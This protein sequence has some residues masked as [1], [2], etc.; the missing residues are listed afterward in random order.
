[1]ATIIASV[2]IFVGIVT[3]HE[4][5]HFAAAK[6]CGVT[7]LE[8]SIGMGPCI[9]QKKHKGTLYSLR[10]IPIGGYCALEG[11]DKESEDEHAFINQS[12]LKRLFI[13]A[14]GAFMN[15]LLG[16]VL[17]CCLM[18]FQN[19]KQVA[20][21]VIS[22]VMENSP[23]Q[24]A[25]LQKND[26]IVKI[27]NSNIKTQADLKFE[28]S[29]YK[30]GDIKLTYL[31]NGEKRTV[32]IT[33]KLIDGE[34][35]IG[36]TAKI[37]PL[38]FGGRIYHAYQYSL[39]FGK[40]ILVS[41]WDVVTGAIGFENM[42]GPVGMVKEINTATNAGIEALL[43]L[44]AIITIN[45]GL[46]NLLPLPALDGG[47]ILF[48]FVE[49]IIRKKIPPEKEGLIHLLGFLLLIA[50]MLFATWNDILRLINK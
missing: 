25:G 10:C 37:E 16:F 1:M 23:A 45:L 32:S 33:P 38:D 30:G 4:F 47:R 20:V 24:E 36:Y 8:F 2:I 19:A 35:L 40:V 14:A 5:G 31:R 21:P 17:M 22:S 44:A 46:F 27:N 49:L 18:F 41:L 29:R 9:F 12:P 50:L 42:S 13:L 43:N 15:I 39:F 7:V 6:I 26:R 3:I 28:L 34:Y 11:E 48:V